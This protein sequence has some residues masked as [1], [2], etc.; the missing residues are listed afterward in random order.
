[1]KEVD[2]FK[3]YYKVLKEEVQKE[4]DKFNEQII[5]EE[6]LFLRENLESFKELNSKGKNIRGFLVKLGYS[7][8]KENQEYANSLALAY[9]VFQTAILVHDDIIDK[10]ET[11][12]EIE[13][14]HYRNKKKYEKD[15][16]DREEVLH[17]SNSIALCIGDYGLFLANKII[18]DAYSKDKNLG[19]VLSCFNQT[20]LNTI[21][22]EVL[23]VMLPFHSKYKE[24]NSKEL[25]KNILEVYRLKTAYYTITGPLK[26]GMLLAGANKKQ[27]EEIEHFAEPLGIAFQI[28]DDILGIYSNETGKVKG[29]DIKEFK[30]TIL[31]S[32][33][34]ETEYKEEFMKIYGQ[35]ITEEKI[36]K[37][38]ELFQRSGSLKY[39]QETRDLLQ[40]E[41]EKQLEK[42][43]WISNEKKILLK[44]FMKYLQER[45]T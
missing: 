32:H 18:S 16:S 25:E 34:M 7:L 30:Q 23:D 44:G 17:F 3:S 11:R 38:Q 2:V 14:I 24:L 5:Q 12:R 35:D 9:E 43:T 4:K 40:K 8:I 31:F 19:K 41:S 45:N 36:E 29:S 20:V 27:L 15:S 33:I 37:I 6:N 13:T 42:I 26:I 28:Q 10:D 22:G 1:M 39:A 21:K